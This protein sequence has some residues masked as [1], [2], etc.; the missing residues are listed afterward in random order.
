[1]AGIKT[2]ILPVN[3]PLRSITLLEDSAVAE[4]LAVVKVTSADPPIFLDKY[5][6]AKASK[7]SR[8]LLV[9]SPQVPA[10]FACALKF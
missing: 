2:V 1:L 9:L 5:P 10:V 3:V 8:L 4:A 7:T 6:A